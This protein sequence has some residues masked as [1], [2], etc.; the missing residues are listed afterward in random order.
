MINFLFVVLHIGLF[1]LLGGQIVLANGGT[2]W[3]AYLLIFTI[4]VV[5]SFPF[6][7]GLGEEAGWR[8][9]ALPKLLE[10]HSPITASAILG[11]LWGL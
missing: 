9:F 1:I 6:G 5:L 10:R 3:Y 4:S 7:S 11:M 8:G 2:P